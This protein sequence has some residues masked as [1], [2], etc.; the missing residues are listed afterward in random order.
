MDKQ[1]KYQNGT[2]IHINDKIMFEDGSLGVVVF[3]MDTAEYS[4]EYPKDHWD[5]LGPGVMVISKVAGL[6][7]Y[8]TE[9]VDFVKS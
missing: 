3:S 9:P 4:R 5:Y 1:M 7:Y 6:I 2:E 8:A